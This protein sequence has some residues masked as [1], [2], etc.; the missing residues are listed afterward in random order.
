MVRCL[1]RG[2]FADVYLGQHIHLNT[3]VAIKVRRAQLSAQQIEQFR[4]EACT[5]A[6]LEHPY[7]VRVLDFGITETFPFL[8]M[9]YAPGGTLRQTYPQGKWLPLATVASYVRQVTA[10]LDYAHREQ[11]HSSRREARKY[12][13]G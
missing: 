4:V 10:A 1:G 6:R 2:G 12:V 3:Q 5:V 9:S 11:V 8:I 13:A 7:I